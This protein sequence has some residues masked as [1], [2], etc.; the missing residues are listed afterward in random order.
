MSGSFRNY[1]V[2]LRRYQLQQYRGKVYGVA[3]TSRPINRKLFAKPTRRPVLPWREGEET[4]FLPFVTNARRSP[5]NTYVR[6]AL[7]VPVPCN[8]AWHTRSG[9]VVTGNAIEHRSFPYIG[10]RTRR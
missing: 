8:V 1:S 4:A 2:C 3:S 6:V 9:P 10:C 7:S 5:S